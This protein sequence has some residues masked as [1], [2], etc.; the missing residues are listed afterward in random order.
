MSN[1]FL[2]FTDL[3]RWLSKDDT[4]WHD[5]YIMNIPWPPENFFGL[6]YIFIVTSLHLSEN[7]KQVTSTSFTK[8]CFPCK[9]LCRCQEA[10]RLTFYSI[11]SLVVGNQFHAL[12][13]KIK[14]FFCTWNCMAWPRPTCYYPN[15]NVVVGPHL[16]EWGKEG[17]PL[18]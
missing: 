14:Y 10:S 9:M 8:R 15:L 11:K 12:Q 4:K 18:R 5:Y 2:F 6:L 1:Y 7:Y 17:L 13:K 16:S 3:L